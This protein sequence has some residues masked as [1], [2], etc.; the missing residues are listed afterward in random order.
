[1]CGW[2]FELE[3][4]VKRQLELIRVRQTRQQDSIA[5]T[6][7]DWLLA[8]EPTASRVLYDRY[9]YVPD[10]FSVAQ[11]SWGMTAEEVRR[12]NPQLLVVND[13]IRGRFLSIDRA[14]FYYDPEAFMVIHRFYKSLEAET[15]GF[16]LLYVNGPVHIYRRKNP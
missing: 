10:A 6:A 8:N 3:A 13:A 12:V 9:S 11:P 2:M 7:G 15:S 4:G 16:E 1:L 14:P 5:V